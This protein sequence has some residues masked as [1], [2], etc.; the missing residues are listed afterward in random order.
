MSLDQLAIRHNTDKST[1]GH[2]YTPI[3]DKFF[4]PLRNYSVNLLELGAGGYHHKDKGFNGTK[5]WAD[6][7]VSGYVTT[8]DIHEKTPPVNDRI[9]FYQGS[10]DDEVF[11]KKVIEETGAPDIII[12]DCSHIS[13]LTVRS[14]EIL[15]PFL[16]PGGYYVVEDLEASYWVT[17]GADGTDFKG[18]LNNPLAIMNF[19]KSLT[20]TINRGHSGVAD[21]GIESIHFYE[22][23][24][25]IKKK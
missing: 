2:G 18:G 25:F 10:Q 14:F 20:D 12:D 13:P 11:L 16:K 22:K 5:M 9:R 23:I 21:L 19:L 15:W 4:S 6:Y 7:F 24:A 3:Y 1:L 17:P 8:I